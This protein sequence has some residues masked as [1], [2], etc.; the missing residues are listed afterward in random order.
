LDRRPSPAPSRRRARR[1]LRARH[2]HLPIEN[3]ERH[4]GDAELAHAAVHRQD[5]SVPDSESRYA[6]AASRES[7]AFA[8]HVR[9]H[10]AVADEAA[11]QKI[12]AEQALDHLLRIAV[13]LRPR[14]EP[15]R[16]DRVGLTLDSLEREFDA[17]RPARRANARVD[18]GGALRPPNFASR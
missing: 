7:P 3:E 1:F 11:L 15:V 12:R 18:P 6:R 4:A 16:I 2:R 14:D 17:D 8:R 5:V 13:G 9:Q 10:I